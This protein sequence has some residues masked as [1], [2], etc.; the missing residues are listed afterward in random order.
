MVSGDTLSG[1]CTSY[2]LWCSM[3]VICESW[4]MCWVVTSEADVSLKRWYFIATRAVCHWFNS[5]SPG[6]TSSNTLRWWVVFDTDEWALLPLLR[7]F[8]LVS[9]LYTYQGVYSLVI[10]TQ[11]LSETSI[12]FL[13][14]NHGRFRNWRFDAQEI[15]EYFKVLTVYLFELFLPIIILS[16]CQIVSKRCGG[17]IHVHRII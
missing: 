2:N 4:L 12:I 15:L 10:V 16:N 14:L 17:S 13:V 7:H 11:Q 5:P 8:K 1:C 6:N 9:L 3:L